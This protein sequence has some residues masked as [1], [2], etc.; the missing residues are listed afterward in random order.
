MKLLKKLVCMKRS[1]AGVSLH[2]MSGAVAFALRMEEESGARLDSGPN[3]LV[4]TAVNNPA[5]GV[6]KQGS[7]IV[8]VK[9]SRQH[10]RASD[11]ALN[12][13]S[14]GPFTLCGWALQNTAVVND[15]AA[16][17]CRWSSGRIYLTGNS[18]NGGQPAWL[19]LTLQG[20]QNRHVYMTGCELVVG[21]WYFW[22]LA[23]DGLGGLRGRIL[24]SAGGGFERSSS[25]S[26]L[27]VGGIDSSPS[28]TV[29][30]GSNS[31]GAANFDGKLDEIWAFDG[32]SFTEEDDEWVY[33]NNA[34]RSFPEVLAR[35]SE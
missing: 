32:Y 12:I 29:R 27:A 2:P 30:I 1:P 11:A 33:N 16:W 9:S 13:G 17:I 35:V 4:F 19:F 25:R 24:S 10:L 31:G 26:D 18:N 21:E 8:L 34:G 28:D 14:S 7:G 20:G 23:I 3:E 5:S 22:V 15:G 6:G